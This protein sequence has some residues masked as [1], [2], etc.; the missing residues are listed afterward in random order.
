[1]WSRYL[2]SYHIFCLFLWDICGAQIR[3]SVLASALVLFNFITTKIRGW[4]VFMVKECLC[5]YTTKCMQPPWLSR[6]WWCFAFIYASAKI[7]CEWWWGWVTK[8]KRFTC[9]ISC[10]NF[11]YTHFSS[12]GCILCYDVMNTPNL[13]K[14]ISRHLPDSE[15]AV[16]TT[17][18]FIGSES[19]CY[20]EIWEA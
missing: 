4:E 7:I 6:W 9:G 3:T 20:A 8:G 12:L 13:F 5:L 10:A 16:V 17:V 2:Y 15:L 1:M 18:E 14:R 11:M 19:I